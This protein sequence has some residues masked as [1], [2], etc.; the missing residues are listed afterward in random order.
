M[1]YLGIDF[2]QKRIG[3]AISDDNGEM[4]FPYNV[5]L[6]NKNSLEEINEIIKKEKINTVIIGE[7]KNFT[8]EPN[9]IMPAIED[10]KKKLTEKTKLKIFFE[11]EFMTS[12]QAERVQGKN[13]MHDASAATIILQTYLDKNSYMV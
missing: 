10:F 11:S 8:G 7:S 12:V 4:A 13:K 1:K 5:V 6:N 2:G 3:L 9:S